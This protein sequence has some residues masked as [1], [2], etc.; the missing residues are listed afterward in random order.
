MEENT[1]E[2]GFRT[3]WVEKEL[4]HGQMGEYIKENT[5][6]I[7]RRG[8]EYLFG[9]IRGSMLDGGRVENNMERELML[10]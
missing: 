3:K 7:G 9:L 6:M 10:A 2:I 1:T 4:S 5:E 8:L